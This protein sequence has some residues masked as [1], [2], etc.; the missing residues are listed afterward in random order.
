M[1]RWPAGIPAVTSGAPAMRDG[2]IRS[3]RRYYQ[4]AACQQVGRPARTIHAR[5]PSGLARRHRSKR[6]DLDAARDG[7][8][9]LL[10]LAAGPPEMRPMV[11][12]PVN[13]FIVSSGSEGHLE[14]FWT[15]RAS[16]RLYP[17]E[18]R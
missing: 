7:G 18:A 8:D 9:D 5:S 6:G 1:C 3:A 15:P 14:F 4:Q 17:A 10:P 2:L 12:E 16:R 13:V 11:A